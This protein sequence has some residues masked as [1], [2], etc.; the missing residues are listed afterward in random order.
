MGQYNKRGSYAGYKKNNKEREALDYYATPIEEVYNIL[1]NKPS[2]PMAL[3]KNNS[4]D[5]P[6]K[7][8]EP[9]VGGGHMLQ[10]IINWA[11]DN[12]IYI[13]IDCTDVKDRGPKDFI[14]TSDFIVNINY[15][16]DQDFLSDT[17]CNLDKTYDVIIMNPPFSIIEPFVLRALELINEEYGILIMFGRTKFLESAGRYNNIFKNDA[18]NMF[19][20][21]IERVFCCKNGDFSM[22]PASIEAYGWFIW[23]RF[24][25]YLHQ[26]DFIH[27]AGEKD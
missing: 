6:L 8:L 3:I 12:N 24:N 11:K 20:Q 10:G 19:Y 14:K 4:K 23:D 1:N 26:F 16:L 7:I 5:N 27:R 13:S 22:K 21:Y 17:Y 9:C 2:I 25:S 15:N 18:P